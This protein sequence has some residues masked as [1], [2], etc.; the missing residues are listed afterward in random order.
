[1][2]WTAEQLGILRQGTDAGNQ[3]DAP[4]AILEAAG[5]LLGPGRKPLAVVCSAS[6]TD[7]Q[8][9][10]RLAILTESALI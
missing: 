8:V 2:E 4:R 5:S 1:M 6:D 7:H 10:W 3:G 9:I